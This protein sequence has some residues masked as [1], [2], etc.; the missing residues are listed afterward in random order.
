MNEGNNCDY[1][2][3]GAGSAGAVLAN[4]LSEDSSTSVC[5]LEA[6]PPDRSPA[7]HIPVGVFRLHLMEKVNW[8]FFTKPQAQMKDRPVFTPRGKTLGG[9]SSIN[10]MVYVRG[11]PADYDDW[12]AAG[13]PGWGWADVK[14]YFLKAEHNEQF[15][16]DDY[17][18]K[19]G[20]LNVTFPNVK[21][22]LT[23]EFVE[24]AA[25]LQLK[26]NPDFNGETMDGVGQHQVTQKNGQRWS[27]AKAY[28][29]PARNRKNL[30]IVTEAMVSRVLLDGN[31]ATGVE[32]VDGRQFSANHEVVVSA[33][34][35]TSPKLLQLSGIG[36]GDELKAHGIPLQH[37][38]P[39]V[40]KNLQDHAA[41]AVQIKTKSR[42]PWG[43]SWPKAPAL[44]LDV[45]RYALFRTG[46]FSANI[47][48]SG[49]FIRTD[50]DLDRPDVQIVFVP[51]H[52]APPPKVIEVGHGYSCFAVLLRPESRGTVSLAS[53]KPED[54]PIIDPQ[55]FSSG[56]DLDVLARGL[57]ESRRIAHGE[58]FQKYGLTEA[59]PGAKVQNDAQLKDYI[60][61]F[62]GTIF[63]PVGT[64]KMGAQDDP[65]AVVD[66]RLRV[67]GIDGLRVVDASIMP[68]IC[69]GN[70]NAPAIMI[71]E[72]G[73][74][75]IV[76]D[77]RG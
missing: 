12:A 66:E 54:A 30:T 50:P 49:G 45:L 59:M 69:S 43:V 32:L 3:V 35:I 65:N 51:G 8:R 33:G 37:H 72:K 53:A 24:S 57:A 63:H 55:F 17:H 28:I 58:P 26:H 56:D 25:A 2:I 64:C 18:S 47:I 7:I 22:P 11:H 40:G 71:G 13:N 29:D 67:R 36:D 48:E 34:A 52:R 14:P 38:L 41:A 76:E 75:M 60:R 74:S 10:G 4:R 20:P 70:T 19:G 31:K 6:G 39:G 77:A 15:G 61:Q 44:A 5:L 21:S 68:T 46:I 73:A 1:I 16:P 9:T 62:G 42:T 27:T 23:D